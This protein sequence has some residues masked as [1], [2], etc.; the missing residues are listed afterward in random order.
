M[1]IGFIG[2]GNMASAMIG[3]IIKNQV[4][5]PVDILASAKT[6]VSREKKKEELGIAM[7][8]DNR[9]VA[10]F[11]EVLILAVKPFYYE[12]VI[13]EIRDV[14]ADDTI[15]VSIAP[16]KKLIW[17]EGLFE[18]PLKIVRTMPN[19]PALVGEGMSCVCGNA[20]CS[21]EDVDTVCRIFAGFGKT[22]IVEE[23]MIDVVVGV[24]GSS[25][26]YVFMFIEAM[27]DAA[28]ADGMPRAQAYRFAAQAVLGSA[29]MVL[30]TGKHPGGTERYGLLSEGNNNRSCPGAGRKRTA[31]CGFRSNESLCKK[32][33]GSIKYRNIMR[34]YEEHDRRLKDMQGGKR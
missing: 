18:K 34:I 29:K 11:A 5:A 32:G 14:V 15:V 25:P 31:K 12:D 22:E 3:G 7:T 4:V 24:S 8:A 16:G 9:E 33:T 28:V 2:C 1:K 17:I 27:A 23:D 20:K 13:K 10:A 30:E 19:T 26:A 21:S 6:E